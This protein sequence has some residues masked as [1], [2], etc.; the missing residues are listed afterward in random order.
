MN[1]RQLIVANEERLI[2]TA[3]PPDVQKVSDLPIKPS[4]FF[5]ALPNIFRGVAPMVAASPHG[6]A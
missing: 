1:R 5:A 6:G 4:V 3:V 2:P